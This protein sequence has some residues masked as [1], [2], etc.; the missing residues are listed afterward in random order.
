MEYGLE[1]RQWHYPMIFNTWHQWLRYTCENENCEG[2]GP[3]FFPGNKNNPEQIKLDVIN[4][5]WRSCIKR[6]GASSPEQSLKQ[7]CI[8]G[9]NLRF[10]MTNVKI[11]QWLFASGGFSKHKQKYQWE[12]RGSYCRRTFVWR[13]LHCRGLSLRKSACFLVVNVP[14]FLETPPSGLTNYKA[15]DL[16][17]NLNLNISSQDP[18]KW[19][20]HVVQLQCEES[21]I[22]HLYLQ[23]KLGLSAP[24]Q[25]EGQR[26]VEQM[27]K[28][29]S[30]LHVVCSNTP[31]SII[32][33]YI[34][35]R[36]ALKLVCHVN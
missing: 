36:V 17:L 5:E 9:W 34:W 15:Q 25:I 6:I 13:W 11:W 33:L 14:L 1:F 16:N 19:Y 12:S 32:T 35:F 8:E 26:S 29:L 10:S 23:P 24:A 27:H 7:L 30:R 18:Q 3:R 28:G 4:V 20:S 22:P 2:G 31:G 21:W